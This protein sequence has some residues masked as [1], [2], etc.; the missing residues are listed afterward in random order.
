MA[1][2]ATTIN[3]IVENMIVK[4]T[5]IIPITNSNVNKMPKQKMLIYVNTLA[6]FF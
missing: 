3:G 6:G 1:I 5:L 2:T 4:R